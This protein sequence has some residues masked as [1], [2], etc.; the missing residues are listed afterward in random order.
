M[1][2]NSVT[3]A[4]FFNGCKIPFQCWL[5]ELSM[6]QTNRP[7]SLL[8]RITSRVF[9]LFTLSSH[10]GRT[11]PAM[12][13]HQWGSRHQRLGAPSA[14]DASLDLQAR[15]STLRQSLA[16]AESATATDLSQEFPSGSEGSG[17]KFPLTTSSG[18]FY[19][20]SRRDLT[21]TRRCRRPKELG[22][23]SCLAYHPQERY[24]P[25]GLPPAGPAPSHT[26]DSDRR[27]ACRPI[28][29][30]TGKN[31]SAT[32]RQLSVP[33]AS[34]RAAHDTALPLV[35][36]WTKGQPRWLEKLLGS[37]WSVALAARLRFPTNHM[38]HLDP[39][40]WL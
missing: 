10:L 38:P 2:L 35:P 25:S 3:I 13:F 18:D 22:I 9:I 15:D 1:T 23:A 5:T 28:G 33:Q 14:S 11:W 6:Q 4:T 27:P 32:T 34:N 40:P 17:C 36:P 29:T 31:S 30:H 39:S 26:Q 16:A 37:V 20:V 24:P 19:V 21:I 7:G 12:Q 8:S